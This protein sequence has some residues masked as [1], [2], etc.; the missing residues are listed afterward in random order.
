MGNSVRK[1]SW[2]YMKR[3][4]SSQLISI[5][6]SVSS[7]DIGS[8]VNTMNGGVKESSKTESSSSIKKLSE[9]LSS[10]SLK[11]SSSKQLVLSHP[12]V[13]NDAF[14]GIGDDDL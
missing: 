8:S 1:N 9:K 6:Q 11:S 12:F 14:E 4:G 2:S 5:S 10:V 7:D 3:D 13:E